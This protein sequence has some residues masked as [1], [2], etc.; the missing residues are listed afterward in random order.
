MPRARS[1]SPTP[2]LRRTSKVRLVSIAQMRVPEAGRT[3]RRFS[4]AQAD[5]Y[6][7]NLDLDK[8]GIPI[9][10]FR[11]GIYWVLDGQH[12]RYALIANG[13]ENDSI[14]CEVYENLSDAEAADVFLGRDDRRAINPFEKFQIA[15]T[16]EH[17]RETDIRRTVEAQGLKVSQAGEVGCV[18][19]V[20][21]LA[22]VYD[23]G[24]AVVLGQALRTIRDAFAADARAFD[25]AIIQGL[26][27]FFHRYADRAS[28]HDLVSRLARVQYGAR[29]LLQR[30]EA[31][32]ERTG[33][34][35]VHCLA[36]CVVEVYNKTRHK[37]RLPSW[38]KADTDAHAAA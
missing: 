10:N 38:W 30:A 5:E 35:R 1:T 16:A 21:A 32:R 13:F 6:A 19:A 14:E 18:G 3:Q 28:E 34:Q 12:R 29:G 22:K 26:G 9:V 37:D 23:R 17:P 20:G 27:L 25:G 7:A 8:L 4:K 36:A 31:M 33:N 24:G 15:C 2:G 11:D